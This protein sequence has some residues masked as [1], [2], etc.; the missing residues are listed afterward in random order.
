MAKPPCEVNEKKRS[1]GRGGR[2]AS[3]PHMWRPTPIRSRKLGLVA[4][5]HQQ[6]MAERVAATEQRGKAFTALA[7]VVAAAKPVAGPVPRAAG[8]PTLQ[9]FR[10]VD[11][12][13]CRRCGGKIE[14][15]KKHECLALSL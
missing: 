15:D 9:P 1:T 6:A 11:P 7:H 8:V 10:A 3:R 5:K 2:G 4:V 13:R 14:R 12:K